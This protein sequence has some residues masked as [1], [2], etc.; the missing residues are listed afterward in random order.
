MVCVLSRTWY[1]EIKSA[2]GPMQN[3]PQTFAFRFLMLTPGLRRSRRRTRS[4]FFGFINQLS[5]Y[6][7]DLQ[8]LD[9]Y[10]HKQ[11]YVKG[12]RHTK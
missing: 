4:E 5:T 9:H 6:C 2:N 8:C 7:Q 11:S 3:E 10:V 12:L 1:K